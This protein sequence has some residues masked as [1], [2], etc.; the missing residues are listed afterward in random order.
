[1]GG[2]TRTTTVFF[3]DHCCGRKAS[4]FI[5]RL[6]SLGKATSMVDGRF[7]FGRRRVS[8]VDDDIF[9]APG[10]LKGLPSNKS[11]SSVLLERVREDF[12][13]RKQLA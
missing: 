5:L 7:V 1:M 2:L 4:I 11:V 8:C 13:R 12:V 6:G 10:S 9:T 3:V